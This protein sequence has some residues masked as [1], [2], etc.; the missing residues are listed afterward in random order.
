MRSVGRICICFFVCKNNVRAAMSVKVFLSN[1]SSA[2]FCFFD[3]KN[4]DV[5]VMALPSQLHVL[6]FTFLP[7]KIIQ[8]WPYQRNFFIP[9]ILS[10]FCLFNCK[11]CSVK[12]ATLSYRLHISVLT[13]LFV[14]IVMQRQLCQHHIRLIQYIC[15]CFNNCKNCNA[16]VTTLLSLSYVYLFSF[17]LIKILIRVVILATSQIAYTCFCLPLIKKP[18]VLPKQLYQ[19]LVKLYS[20]IFAFSV[21][22]IVMGR[23]LYQWFVGPIAYI[24]FCFF[25]CKKTLCIAGATMQIVCQVVYNGF[26]FISI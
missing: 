20:S 9:Y 18:S 24:C 22:K 15:F 19:Q 16:I 7:V 21:V 17:S 12:A 5:E 6:I 4:R 25:L 14:Q 13:F 11:N 26:G 10:F 1:I 23:Q 8:A 2:L 3:C